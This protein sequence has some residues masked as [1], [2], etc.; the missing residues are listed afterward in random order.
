MALV[1]TVVSETFFKVLL[2]SVGGDISH[3]RK[4]VSRI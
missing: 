3:E 4:Y 2:F 1:I